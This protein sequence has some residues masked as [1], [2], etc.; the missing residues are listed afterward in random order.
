MTLNTIIKGDYIEVLKKIPENSLKR[1][2]LS[3]TK[4][5]DVVLDPFFG[6][7]TTGAIAR[8][9]KRNFIG[10]EKETEYI[11]LAK[12]RIANLDCFFEEA[13]W[14]EEPNKKHGK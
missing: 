3:T 14:E 4:Q 12:K 1:V 7:G 13:E 5:G 11:R 9:L 6:T 8:K 2:I 10:I